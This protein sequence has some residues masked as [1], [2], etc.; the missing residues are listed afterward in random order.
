MGEA[1]ATEALSK[2]IGWVN[3]SEL[4]TLLSATGNELA[5]LTNRLLAP[6]PQKSTGVATPIFGQK[7]FEANGTAW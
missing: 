1:A 2:V 4:A 7:C 3:W 6:V 5:T